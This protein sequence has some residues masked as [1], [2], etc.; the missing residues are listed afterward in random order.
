MNKKSSNLMNTVMN[1]GGTN[2]PL[3]TYDPDYIEKMNDKI[4]NKMEEFSLLLN[5]SLDD[6]EYARKLE[7]AWNANQN[8]QNKPYFK[9]NPKDEEKIIVDLK[10]AM[11]KTSQQVTNTFSKDYKTYF[12]KYKNDEQRIISELPFLNRTKSYDAR[13]IN[14]TIDNWLAEAKQRPYKVEVDK[15][16][17]DISGRV[18]AFT[19]L[20]N[21]FLK[22]RVTLKYNDIDGSSLT[23]SRIAFFGCH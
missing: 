19:V 6:L 18:S 15:T 13:Q 3:P 4:M 10:E 14:S 23:I 11:Q 22:V 2:L 1:E 12:K 5:S 21:T 16:D 9:Y 20:V 17:S 8:N 7:E